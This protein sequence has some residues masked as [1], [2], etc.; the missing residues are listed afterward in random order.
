MWIK[1]IRIRSR[2][3]Q[4]KVKNDL[5][6]KFTQSI[7]LKARTEMRTCK[8]KK[9]KPKTNNLLIEEFP[10]RKRRAKFA[11]FSSKTKKKYNRLTQTGKLSVRRQTNRQHRDRECDFSTIRTTI[12]PWKPP[13]TQIETVENASGTVRAFYQSDSSY[14]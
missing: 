6:T 10:N 8:R 14:R 12:R 1:I 3:I 7:K 4:T 11:R 5:N 13:I 2:F 9:I